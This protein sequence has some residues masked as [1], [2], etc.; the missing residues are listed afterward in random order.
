[1]SS[2]LH[3][4]FLFEIFLILPFK[5]WKGSAVLIILLVG[6]FWHSYVVYTVFQKIPVPNK[7]NRKFK[8]PVY[9]LIKL[10]KNRLDLNRVKPD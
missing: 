7:N 5:T 8:T 10:Q 4:I 9:K 1:M 2:E 3:S 6:E